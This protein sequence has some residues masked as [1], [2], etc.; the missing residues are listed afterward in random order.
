MEQRPTKKLKRIAYGEIPAGLKIGMSQHYLPDHA[1]PF[2]AKAYYG[3]GENSFGYV[4]GYEK[5]GKVFLQDCMHDY[6]ETP[7]VWIPNPD[8]FEPVIIDHMSLIAPDRDYEDGPN[9][10]DLMAR[11]QDYFPHN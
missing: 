8:Y 5:D 4:S 10:T 7:V 9:L 2:W 1:K 6:H 11:M 3:E